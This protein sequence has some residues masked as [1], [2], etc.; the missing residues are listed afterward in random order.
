MNLDLMVALSHLDPIDREVLV[1]LEV[2]ERSHDQVA[3]SLGVTGRAVTMHRHKA[4]I[5]LRKHFVGCGEMP[6]GE[7]GLYAYKSLGCRCRV[8]RDANRAK[9][10]A[11]NQAALAKRKQAA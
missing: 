9:N 2:L 7:H 8:C 1:D 11:C 10:L 4:L 3:D 6:V 5:A